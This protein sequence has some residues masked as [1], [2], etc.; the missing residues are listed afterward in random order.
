M[1]PSI[2]ASS[3]ASNAANRAFWR[4]MV[5]ASSRLRNWLI[6]GSSS[7]SVPS[8]SVSARPVASWNRWS[9]QPSTLPE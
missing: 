5:S 4:S 2:F 9:E 3:S 6:G 7:L 1:A 8:R